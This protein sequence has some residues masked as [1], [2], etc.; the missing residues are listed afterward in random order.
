MK[1]KLVMISAAH[2]RGSAVAFVRGEV[3]P[4]GSVFVAYS[5]IQ[6]LLERADIQAGDLYALGI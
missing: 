2:M 5:H 6:E 1:S 3:R 4:D